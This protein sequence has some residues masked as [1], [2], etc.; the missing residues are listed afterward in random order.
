MILF[1]DVPYVDL[2]ISSLEAFIAVTHLPLRQL[3][4]L[5]SLAELSI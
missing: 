5:V 1:W 3:D 2:L 4:F